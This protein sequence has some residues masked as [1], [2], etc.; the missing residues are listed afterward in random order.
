M[1]RVTGIPLPLGMSQ[2][3]DDTARRPGVH[4]PEAVIDPERFFDDLD[5]NSDDTSIYIVDR[6]PIP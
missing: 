5:R 6:E 1:A 2:I 3:I 4:P